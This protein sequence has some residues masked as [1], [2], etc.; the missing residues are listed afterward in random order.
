MIVSGIVAC[1]IT[2]TP[3]RRYECLASWRD[4]DL[5]Y[6][7]TRPLGDHDEHDV[8][9]VSRS[10]GDRVYVVMSDASC[11]NRSAIDFMRMSPVDNHDL[12]VLQPVGGDPCPA[13]PPVNGQQPTTTDRWNFVVATAKPTTTVDYVVHDEYWSTTANE[14]RAGTP[15]TMN[16]A[17]A[18]ALI[19]L[20]TYVCL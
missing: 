3:A 9:F 8:C 13:R 2:P 11:A 1:S 6:D 7:L 10:V 5:T 12:M 15:A 20:R 4:G 17:L 19:I 14:N 18:A 16:I